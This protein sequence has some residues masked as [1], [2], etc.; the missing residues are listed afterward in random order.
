M[1][2]FDFPF[3]M[4]V[5]AHRGDSYNCYENTMQ[6]FQTAYETGVD[7]IE[8]DVRLTADRQ[9]VLIHD[10]SLGRTSDTK[11]PVKE[12]TL[13]QLQQL[14]VGDE[15]TPLQIPTLE[16]FLA[17]AAPLDLLLNL[18]LKEYKVPGNEGD[19]VYCADETVRLVQ[20]YGLSDRVVFNSFDAAVLDY[21]DRKY[22]HSFRLH[23]FYPY[24][25]MKNVDRDPTEYLYCACIWGANKRKECFDFLIANGIEPWVGASVTSSEALKL[26][27]E[28]GARLVTTNY[29]ADA[30]EK[31]RK[32]GYHA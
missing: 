5:A 20:K 23:G 14:N 21:I 10:D 15:H 24:V 29:P 9:L 12:R 26:C 30:L 13:A 1:K 11:G 2:T 3:T 28:Y 4:A 18:E 7:M 19:W 27:C 25:G 17:W 8:T 16:E 31:L 22:D 6:A 32:M